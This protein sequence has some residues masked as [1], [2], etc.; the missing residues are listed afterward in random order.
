MNFSERPKGQT[1]DLTSGGVNPTDGGGSSSGEGGTEAGTDGGSS[2]QPVTAF[3]GAKAFNAAGATVGDALNAGHNF[4]G[5]T[6]PTNPAG[7]NCIDCHKAGGSAAGAIWGIAGTIYTSAAGTTPI[8]GAEVRVVDAA[9]K[10]LALVYSDANGNFW[11]DTIVGGVPG[12]AKVGARNATVTKLMSTAL[13]TQDAGCQ[14]GGCH[15]AGSQGRVY[16]Q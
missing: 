5:N 11:S 8:K 9:G 1:G 15:V 12:G 4:A 3:T 2:G 6:P 13:T 16:L 7:Q 10:E 14:K